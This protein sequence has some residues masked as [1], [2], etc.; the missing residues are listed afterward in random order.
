MH[1]V[2]ALLLPYNSFV[3]CLECVLTHVDSVQ[4]SSFTLNSPAHALISIPNY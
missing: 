3:F 2:V 1:D 4:L